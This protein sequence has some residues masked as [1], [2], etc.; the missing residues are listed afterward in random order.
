MSMLEVKDRSS[1]KDQELV[2]RFEVQPI[3]L[4]AV[5]NVK[6]T[7]SKYLHFQ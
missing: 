7:S 5:Q 6:E 4:S 1:W 3:V 2:H